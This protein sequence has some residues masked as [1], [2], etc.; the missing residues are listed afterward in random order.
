MKSKTADKQIAR[1]A[2]IFEEWLTKLGLKWWEIK[3]TYYRKEK[4]FKKD[5][6][7][8][9]IM[10]CWV[11]WQYFTFN[12]D[13]NLSAVRRLDSDDLECAIVH[14]LCHA[15]VNEMTEDDPDGKHEE[16]TVTM[17]TKA[18]MWVRD[19]TRDEFAE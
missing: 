5:N 17:L 1:C 4:Q 14:E 3:I 16:R 15:L 2:P 13:V 18:F 11:K 6:G 8:V 10:R 12:V 7:P 19:L 9:A